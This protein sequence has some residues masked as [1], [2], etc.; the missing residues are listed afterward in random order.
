MVVAVPAATRDSCGELRLHVDEVVCAE[1]PEPFLGVGL[2]YEDFAQ[3]T[4][5]EVQD[6][7]RAGAGA[8]KSPQSPA[9]P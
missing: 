1:A 6:L 9:S 4:D 8:H 2:W 5:D 3:T 7:A